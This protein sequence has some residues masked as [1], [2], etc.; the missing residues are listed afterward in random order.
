M[1]R[2]SH[3]ILPAPHP[4]A[5]RSR[6]RAGFTLIELLVVIAIIAILVS[7]L[8]PAVQQARE[9]ARKA[10]CQN[11]L[12]QLG[13][14]A[15][16]YHSTYRAFPIQGGGTGTPT[17]S[18]NT[19]NQAK[20]SVFV[21]LTQYLDHPTIWRDISTAHDGWPAYGPETGKTN[22]KPWRT[23]IA[24][25]LCPSDG[26]QNTNDA[27]IM[28]DTNY[29]VSWGDNAH[30]VM[31]STDRA[32]ENSRGMFKRGESRAF[33]DVRDGTVNTVLFAEIGRDDNSG[34]YQGGVL[35]NASMGSWKGN[36]PPIGFRTPLRCLEATEN[37]DNP[38][39]YPPS[40]LGDVEPRG[41]RWNDAGGAF[42]GFT[43][44]L[45]PNGPSCSRWGNVDEDV[46][47]SAGSYHPGV[48]QVVMVDGSV[49]TISETI[50]AETA[51]M[52]EAQVTSGRSPYGVW[53]ALGTRNGGEVAEGF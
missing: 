22:Y 17:S 10:Q 27:N 5:R 18:G 20:L 9:A 33:R 19:T 30:G 3:R 45:P 53:G 43:T 25:L 42:T 48:V 7:L 28:A 37:P 29:A 31:E 49:R 46:I 34:A 2:R 11:N 41:N 40:V 26:S 50:D 38:G 47:L 4:A 44:I 16:N 21:P 35:P 52:G 6:R 14:A 13:L 8:L 15:H 39:F 32:L 36:N 23:Q 12:K 24:T 51:G 1:L